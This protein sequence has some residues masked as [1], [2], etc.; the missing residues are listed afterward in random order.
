MKQ[1][2]EHNIITIQP[3]TAPTSAIFQYIFEEPKMNNSTLS[4]KHYIDGWHP[5][6]SL[7]TYDNGNHTINYSIFKSSRT[8]G[9]YVINVHTSNPTTEASK[10]N[11]LLTQFTQFSPTLTEALTAA[12]AIH[13][14]CL[15]IEAEH[16][17]E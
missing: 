9:N 15:K 14:R 11:S 6:C 2:N 13:Q 10:Y 3:M 1:M 12:E 17:Q 4:W 5:F 7:G 8:S 16:V